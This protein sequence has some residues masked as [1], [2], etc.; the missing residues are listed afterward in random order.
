[1]VIFYQICRFLTR[2][3]QCFIKPT[4]C[5]TVGIIKLGSRVDIIIPNANKF[6]LDVSINQKVYGSTTIIGKWIDLY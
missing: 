3:I 6:K 2:R 5:V 1:M 4:Q